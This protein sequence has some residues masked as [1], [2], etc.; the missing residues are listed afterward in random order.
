MQ[1]KTTYV[2][3]VMYP[4]YLLDVIVLQIQHIHSS[5]E[6]S[7]IKKETCPEFFIYIHSKHTWQL[8]EAI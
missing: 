7:C 1:F 6:I 8:S 3:I 5:L 2:K 4:A